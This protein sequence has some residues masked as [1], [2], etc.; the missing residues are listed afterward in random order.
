E[1]GWWDSEISSLTAKEYL[2][3]LKTSGIDTLILGC[4]H[5]PVLKPLIQR[6]MGQKVSLVDSAAAVAEQ[7]RQTLSEFSLQRAAGKGEIAF[8]TS[9]DPA[10]F[11][12]LAKNLL[13]VS[14]AKVQLKK[15]D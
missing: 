11:M 8:Y 9:D 13:G 7:V 12:R 3:P 15:F 5:Y 10:R 1:E 14:P 2:S 4:T 6:A